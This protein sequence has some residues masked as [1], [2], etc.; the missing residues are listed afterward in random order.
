MSDFLVPVAA[1]GVGVDLL[2]EL[3]H[4]L[5]AVPHH[6]AGDPLGHG[7][8]LAADD[9]DAVVEA[10]LVGL[11]DHL[12]G[13]KG[14]PGE[15]RAHLAGAGQAG[16]HA[17]PLVAVARLDDHRIAQPLG[18]RER[19]LEVSDDLLAGDGDREV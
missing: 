8:H 4:G 2:D 7:R 13:D 14:G 10:G 3:A 15:G 9:Q 12:A 17:A 19:L 16:R 18:R 6:V 5:Q 1:P 11:D